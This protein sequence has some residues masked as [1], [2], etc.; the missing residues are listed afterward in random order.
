[1]REAM[2]AYEKADALQADPTNDDAILRYNTCV[3]LIAA[4][5]LKE[6]HRE[7]DTFPLE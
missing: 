1:M 3:R 2:A 6:P 4:N 5:R 7:P